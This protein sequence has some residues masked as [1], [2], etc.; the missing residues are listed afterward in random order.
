MTPSRYALALVALLS[1]LPAFCRDDDDDDDAPPVTALTTTPTASGGVPLNPPRQQRAGLIT[2]RLAPANLQPEANS[3]GKVLDIQPLLELRVRYRTARADAEIASAA[4]TLAT[5]NRDRLHALHQADIVAGRDWLQAEA[6]WQADHAKQDAAH[7][8]M[9]EIRLEAQQ[10]FGP[11]LA[12][13]ALDGDAPL[14]DDFLN[15]RRALILVAL[16]QGYP[17]PTAKTALFVARDLDRT[18]A[19][20]AEALSPATKTDDLIQGE[21]WFYHTMNPRLRSGMRVHVWA[22]LAGGERAGVIVPL[23]AVIWHAGK[24]WVYRRESGDHFARVGLTGY[25]EQSAGWFVEQGLAAGDEI[26]ITGG[27]MLLSEEFRQHIPDEDDD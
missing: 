17:A 1:A 8:L 27:Q 5:K 26:V 11:E 4:Y 25:R 6:Q 23:S 10:A 12:R 14:F 2:T 15:H 3:Y 13:L 22:P 16:P 19:T 24:P 21:T 20:R 7:R 9:A 18:L